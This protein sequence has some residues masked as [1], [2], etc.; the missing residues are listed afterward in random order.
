MTFL[1]VWAVG[2]AGIAPVIVLLYLLKLK[3]RPMPVSTL[4]FWQRI[5]Q[6]NQRR[7]FFQKLRQLFSLLL[8]L[9]IFALILG[10][11]M[12]PTL[13]RQITEGASTVLIVDT[14]AR[15]AA[16]EPDG[17]T[18]FAKAKAEA[19]NVVRQA[20]ALRQMA[21]IS[22]DAGARV[23]TPFTDDEKA[24]RETLGKLSATDA[25]GD[26]QSAINLAGELLASRGGDRRIIVFTDRPAETKPADK[27]IPL[28]F[29]TVGT[30]RDNLAITRF[31][32][33]PVLSSPETSEVLLE[34]A[35]FGTSPAKTNVELAYDGQLLD[36]K[37]LSIEPGGHAVQV[38]PTVPRPSNNARGWLTARLDTKDAL[39]SDNVAYAVLPV[40]PPKRILLVTKGNWFLEK[41][42]A[43]DQSIAFELVTPDSFSAS[44]AAKFDA[45]ICDNFVPSDFNIANP[46]ANFFFLKQTPFNTSEPALD[47]PLISDLDSRQPV[48]RLV[49]LQNITL[50][51]AASLQLPKTEDWNWQAPIRSFEHPLLITGEKRGSSSRVAALALDIGDSDLPLR[52]AFPLLISNTLHW[53]AG[54]E[55]T[56]VLSRRAGETLPLT[57]GESVLTEPQNPWKKA[58]AKSPVVQSLFQPLTNG[59][60]AWQ[61]PNGTRWLAVNTFSEAE[62]DLRQAGTPTSAGLALPTV[63]LARVTGWPLWQYLAAA[64]LLLFALEWW[65]FH[66]R[67]TE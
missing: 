1:N 61:T 30:A 7:A 34:V 31:A 38:F 66:R 28:E 4:L 5:L 2:F 49:N 67:R 64:A 43:A 58:T 22:V 40:E 55:N 8:H 26:L 15:M 18:R 48:L 19:T 65:L 63:S 47:Q 53:L 3:R 27:K 36:V 23:I 24:L 12:H 6:E 32:T 39:A 20:S 50:L 11:L 54:E 14:R 21:M 44:V 46:G 33:R 37:P 51:H 60:Y 62:S 9:L 17:Q 10:A 56:P 42:L 45:V 16:T 41:L 29:V 57:A 25:S 59:F 13:D 52:V 35:N